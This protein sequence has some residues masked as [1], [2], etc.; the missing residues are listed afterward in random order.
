MSREAASKFGQG[1]DSPAYLTHHER[2][3]FDSPAWTKRT[4]ERQGGN[5]LVEGKATDRP[6]T[7]THDRNIRGG[8]SR[9]F[10]PP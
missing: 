9:K 3:L 8:I 1:V 2:R 7:G 6:G 4:G 10:D 5:T